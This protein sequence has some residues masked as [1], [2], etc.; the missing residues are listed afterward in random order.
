MKVQSYYSNAKLL[1][2]GE[3]VILNGSLALALPLVYGQ[4]M[5]VKPLPEPL[6]MWKSWDFHK[7][8]WFEATFDTHTTFQLLHSSDAEL[9][10][11]LALIFRQIRKINPSFLTQNGAEV[12]TYL[13]FN[14]HWGLGT[15]STFLNNLAQW[16]EVDAFELQKEIW[17]G[18]GYD[19]ACAQANTPILYATQDG[20]PIID[21]VQLAWPFADQLYFVY[22]NQKQN[23]HQ[24]IQ[25]F[26]AHTKLN[27]SQVEFFSQL[28]RDIVNCSQ[29]DDFE[30]LLHTHEH[31]LGELLQL[32]P[33]QARLFPDYPGKI[34][35]LGAWGGDFILA[36]RNQA[37]SY[38]PERGYT[39]I[40]PLTQ[41]I[42]S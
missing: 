1:I 40:L 41:V 20:L 30:T 19:I 25:N 34:K 38:F 29:L 33:V 13:N 24:A 37:L 6:L 11:T 14:R 18:S 2:S 9:S 22:L 23:T 39:T 4:S 12:Q 31:T 3:Y 17:G 7:E 10:H 5:E 16:A 42:K 36:T 27:S 35:S 32:T 15:S 28:T 8:C 21:P 26:R